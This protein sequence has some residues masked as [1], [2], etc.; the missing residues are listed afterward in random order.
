MTKSSRT[1]SVYDHQGQNKRRLSTNRHYVNG[2]AFK[3]MSKP[4]LRKN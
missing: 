3:Q 2:N 4:P 1:S